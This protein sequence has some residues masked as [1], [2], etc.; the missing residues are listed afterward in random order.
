MTDSIIFENPK[1]TPGS[2]VQ[3]KGRIDDIEE[4][5]FKLKV[6]SFIQV[7]VPLSET[8]YEGLMNS[9]DP[10][11]YTED[12]YYDNPVKVEVEIDKNGDP[13]FKS[14]FVEKW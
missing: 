7:L 9:D 10:T 3:L 2:I 5:G 4:H 8:D 12:D 1:F 14:I 11:L 6:N 13:I